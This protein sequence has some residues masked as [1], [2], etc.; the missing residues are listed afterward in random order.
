MGY[1]FTGLSSGL[2]AELAVNSTLDLGSNTISFV[3]DQNA[4]GFFYFSY[5][6]ERM[7]TES[8]DGWVSINV[9]QQNDPP[10][11]GCVAWGCLVLRREGGVG[12]VALLV[13]FGPLG[14]GARSSDGV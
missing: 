8:Q 9:L 5:R 6:I 13:R 2:P 11:L 12:L 10:V 14:L 3:A 1:N 4:F 7:G